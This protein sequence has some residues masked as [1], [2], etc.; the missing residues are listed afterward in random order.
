MKT[1]INVR[2]KIHF[3][4]ERFFIVACLAILIATLSV[5]LSYNK[6]DEQEKQKNNLQKI[7]S[8]LS[9]M[10]VPSMI[11]F[12]FLEVRRLLYMASGS[13]ETFII[14]DSDGT[15]IMPDYGKIHFSKFVSHF[16]R[17]I[18]DCKN[19][20][21]TYRYIG[22]KKY[23]I[24]C[25]ILKNNDVLLSDKNVGVLLSFTNYK[26]F[27]FSHTIFYFVGI[28][29]ILFLL[30]IFLFRK[31]LY[32]QLLQPLIILKNNISGISTSHA[33]STPY[34]DEI[35]NAPAE[36]V[37]IKEAFERLLLS[38]KDEYCGRIE[39]E[40]V[41]ALIDLAAGVAHDIRSPLTALDII[42]KDIKNIP[43]E[44][45]I[46]IR[47]AANR[48]NDIANNLLTQ[49]R[50]SKNSELCDTIT[51]IKSELISELLL[52][53]I[54]E[55]RVQYRNDAI[56][57]MINIDEPAYGKFSNISA[58]SF[59]RVLSNLID[60]SKEAEADLIKIRLSALDF[61]NQSK[62][63]LQI[64]DNGCGISSVIFQKIMNGENFS[65]KEKGNGLG[66]PHAIKT[67]EKEWGGKLN[68]K[69]SDGVGTL[70][71]VLLPETTTPK[72]FLS[73]L[74]V[75]PEDVIAILDDDESIHQVWD[76][77][78]K[79]VYANLKFINHYNPQDLLTSH[80]DN[81]SSINFFLIDYEF[82]GYNENGLDIIEKLNIA[83]RSY[84]I[85][86]RYEDFHIR[87]RC[88]KIGLKIIPKAFA[89]YIP[90]VSNKRANKC[91]CS[92]KYI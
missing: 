90:I 79:D 88:E 29:V 83:D 62:L 44:Q 69:I 41:N 24:N 63:C 49:Y 56:K 21:V 39:A 37:E 15:I 9:Q 51:N 87:T 70:I 22:D 40:K 80:K 71:E 73:K 23:L 86:S 33:S 17:S 47:N 61:G 28:L 81:L 32:R 25:S 36:L 82:I 48:I 6:Y 65:T 59:N 91:M 34:L 92:V 84:L 75:S 52:S 18:S 58:S 72:W 76:K 53:L 42:I 50:Q 13:E 7:H 35:N 45:R 38:L 19:L 8:M 55:K 5:G 78:F 12:D 2:K 30:L 4:I 89:V 66:L 10:V 31:M 60:N 14:I 67:I 26:L 46:V 64:Q 74:I 85:T 68:I 57:L 43:E 77:R 16:Y 20:E 11:I 1:K 54:S 3:L 27:S